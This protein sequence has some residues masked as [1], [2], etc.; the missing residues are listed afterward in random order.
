MQIGTFQNFTYSFQEVSPTVD[1]VLDFVQSPELEEEHPALVFMDEIWSELNNLD[2]ITGGY[3]IWEIDQ[4]QQKEGFIEI[5]GSKL[6]INRQLAGYFK[7][8]SHAALFICTAGKYFTEKTCE[9]NEQGNFLEA[10]ILDS[11]GSLTVENAMNKIQYQLAG[12]MAEI[13]LNISNRYS[14]GYCNW[15]LSEQK[16]LFSLIGE[17]PVG[18]TLNNSCL[19]FPTKSVSGI[20][21]IGKT[22]KKRE[23]GCKICNNQT[24]IYRKIAYEKT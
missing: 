12:K 7:N 5:L 14:P 3:I 4:L 18:I 6:S 23:Y 21:G 1:E 10:Y 2:S 24:C 9:L 15:A 8:A 22:I 16:K 11:I 19:M 13:G 17:N 20:I